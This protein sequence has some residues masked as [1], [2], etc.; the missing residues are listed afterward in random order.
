MEAARTRLAHYFTPRPHLSRLF[1]QLH[2]SYCFSQT[3]LS[4]LL[5]TTPFQP[6]VLVASCARICQYSMAT[7]AVRVLLASNPCTCRGWMSTCKSRRRGYQYQHRYLTLRTISFS[8][9]CAR[10]SQQFIFLALYVAAV[11]RIWHKQVQMMAL[12]ARQKSLNPSKFPS[13][14]ESS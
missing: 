10:I 2:L 6:F 9:S 11:E 13:T 4:R 3:H 8:A 7:E 1:A 5:P 14:L 12:A